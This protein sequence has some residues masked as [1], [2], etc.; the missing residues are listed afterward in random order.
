LQHQRPAD[1]DAD[2]V[3]NHHREPGRLAADDTGTTTDGHREPD[4]LADA[5]T[6][7]NRHREPGCLTDDDAATR[8][9]G[10]HGNGRAHGDRRP[11]LYPSRDASDQNRVA[12]A[13]SQPYR[14][15]RLPPA[16]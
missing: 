10:T 1:A 7:P 12:D 3:A 11:H 14:R 4:C 2:T 16:H 5:G 8:D 6:S 13:P 9:R 15:H